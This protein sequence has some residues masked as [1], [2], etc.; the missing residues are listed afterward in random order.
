MIISK[1]RLVEAIYVLEKSFIL[2]VQWHPKFSY[3][4]D[5]NSIDI[6]KDLLKPVV[7]N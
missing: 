7:Y 5:K 3:H 2:I 6:K 1:D 4:V